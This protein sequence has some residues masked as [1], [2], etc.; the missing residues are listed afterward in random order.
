MRWGG[1]AVRGASGGALLYAQRAHR[2]HRASRPQAGLLCS[3]VLTCS[4]L[5]CW[6]A[7]VFFTRPD[8]VWWRP[9]KPWCSW[10]QDAVLTCEAPGCDVAWVAPRAHLA[11]FGR[12]HLFR[13]ALWPWPYVSL[14]T[15]AQTL[16]LTG[17]TS[18][19]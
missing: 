18:S 17:G 15:L 8:L 4:I 1:E 16:T 9:F 2:T 5:A 3:H 6:A 10:P 12:Q 19:D 7:L 14:Q 11:R 13:L